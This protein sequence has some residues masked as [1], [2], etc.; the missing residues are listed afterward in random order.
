MKDFHDF[1]DD[2]M[3]DSMGQALTKKSTMYLF[4]FISAV[5]SLLVACL[6]PKKN[7]AS[8][9]LG[10]VGATLWGVLA[11]TSFVQEKDEAD[12]LYELASV[13]DEAVEE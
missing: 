9:A 7:T 10:A 4:A 3:Q 8:V 11:Y 6:S 12:A 1:L 2:T 5:C 13:A